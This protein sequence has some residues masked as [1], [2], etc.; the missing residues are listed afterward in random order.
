MSKHYTAVLKV[1]ATEDRK[2][3]THYDA[4]TERETAEVASVVIRA[5]SLE[6]LR[7]KLAAHVAL[8]EE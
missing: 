8:I 1:H 6:A 3:G 5:T 7:T 4:P 2:T